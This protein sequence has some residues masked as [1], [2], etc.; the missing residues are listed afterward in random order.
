GSINGASDIIASDI[1]GR[2]TD[3]G[4]SITLDT[5]TTGSLIDMS[6][7]G[8][9]NTIT[10]TNSSTFDTTFNGLTTGNNASITYTQQGGGDMIAGTITTSG[11][12]A[13]VSLTS[14]EAIVGNPPATNILT[15]GTDSDITLSAGT[16]IDSVSATA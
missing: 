2:T 12:D 7:V 4:G 6:T 16:Y 8:D 11:I 10:V 15:T 14:T 1:I 5:T 3:L 9:N 13:D